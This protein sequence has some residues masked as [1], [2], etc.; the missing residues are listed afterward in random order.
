MNVAGIAAGRMKS[1]TGMLIT[2]KIRR[3]IIIIFSPSRCIFTF[4]TRI[5]MSTKINHSCKI[6]KFFVTTNPDVGPYGLGYCDI[7]DSNKF[8]MRI[9]PSLFADIGNKI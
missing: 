6:T 3:R 5:L 1:H 2:S 9:F 7:V 8:E 4:I